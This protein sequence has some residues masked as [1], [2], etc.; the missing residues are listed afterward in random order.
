MARFE[1]M[2]GEWWDPRGKFAP[3][4]RFNPVRLRFLRDRAARHFGHDPLSPKPLEG[5]R[6]LDIGCGGG[7]LAEPLARMGARVTGIDAGAGNIAVARLHGEQSGLAI[8][9]RHA[10]ADDLAGA[11]ERFDLVLNMEVVE[12]VA[13]LD[14]Y[15]AASCAL[16]ADGGATVIATL[17]RTLKSFALA[18]I[19]AE[20]VLGWLPRGTHDWRRFVTP[21]ELEARLAANGFGTHERVGMRYD[22]L[23]DTWE[24]TRDVSVNYAVF[25]TRG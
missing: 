3:L 15:L 24:E 7:L 16:V 10:T 5:L 2:A 17:N 11:G 25:A 12:H 18:I 9:Y 1:A 20:Y 22:P 6:V 4:H 23:R 13:D 21:D 8:A 19:G 14:A